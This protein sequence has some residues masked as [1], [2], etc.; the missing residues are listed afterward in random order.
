[1][2]DNVNCLIT[3]PADDGN[4][5]ASLGYATDD[6]LTQALSILNEQLTQGHKHKS[7]IAAC[8]RELRWRERNRIGRK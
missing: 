1:M 4:F 2:I 7:R 6:E 3:V 5:K 8:E